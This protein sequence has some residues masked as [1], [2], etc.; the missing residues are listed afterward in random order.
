MRTDWI[1]LSQPSLDRFPKIIESPLPPLRILLHLKV[2]HKEIKFLNLNER[3]LPNIIFFF[4]QKLNSNFTWYFSFL[5]KI[6]LLHNILG[7]FTT[8]YILLLQKSNF[9]SHWAEQY[10]STFLIARWLCLPWLSTFYQTKCYY[11]YIY[12][13]ASKV[14]MS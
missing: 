11:N 10:T 1:H 6:N 2:L 14:N 13:P 3:V 8:R 7:R 5:I 12:L 4:D 9:Y